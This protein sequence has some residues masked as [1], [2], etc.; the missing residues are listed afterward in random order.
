MTQYGSVKNR[1]LGFAI[2]TPNKVLIMLGSVP[3]PNLLQ[4][5]FLAITELYC[6]ITLRQQQTAKSLYPQ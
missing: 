5:K 4:F 3:P 1:R 6:H 2:A